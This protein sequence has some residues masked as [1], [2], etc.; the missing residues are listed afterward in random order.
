M[1]WLVCRLG[2]RVWDYSLTL[3]PVIRSRLSEGQLARK[4]TCSTR[5]SGMTTYWLSLGTALKNHSLTLP[6]PGICEMA[7][8]M[9]LNSDC[10]MTRQLLKSAT[11]P[12]QA[13]GLYAICVR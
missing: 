9:G 1:W 7:S 12:D 4:R 3:Q 10:S 2:K 11:D 8:T 13:G 6:Y 5:D